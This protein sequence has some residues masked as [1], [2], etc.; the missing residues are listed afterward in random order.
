VT[1]QE[2]EQDTEVAY[3]LGE[4][5]N[6]VSG[7]TGPVNAGSGSQ[8]NVQ[9]AVFAG[10]EFWSRPRRSHRM[11][12]EDVLNELAR[13]FAEPPGFDGLRQRLRV[14]GTVL[15]TGEPGTGRRTTA[16]MVLHGCGDAGRFR[17]LPDHADEAQPVLDPET[18]EPGDRLLLD[19]S[20]GLA[21]RF[22]QLRDQL[23]DHHSVVVRTGAYLVI[24][25]PAGADHQIPGELRHLVCT[26]QRPDGAE[27]LRRHLLADGVSEPFAGE[28]DVPGL[29]V[30]L[31]SDPM[32]ELAKLARLVVETRTAAE[33][34]GS[35][36]DWLGDAVAAM[37]V[38]LQ[39]VAAQ[40]RDNPD[41]RFRALLLASAMFEKVPAEV[42]YHAVD[43]LLRSV[44][45]PADETHRLE[46][47]DLMESL[48][49]I[50]ACTDREQRVRLRTVTYGSATRIHF[51]NSFPGLRA[52][53][54]SWL[55][56]ALRLAMRQ[57]DRVAVL[58]RYSAEC[59]RTEHAE[60]LFWLVDRWAQDL[61]AA[62]PLSAASEVLADGLTDERYGAMF[63]RRIYEW[64]INRRLPRSLALHLVRLCAEAIAP[65]R[66]EQALVRLR[67]LTRNV[68][69][70][71]STAARDTMAMLAA[72]DGHFLRRVLHR[73][74]ED[75]RRPDPWPT[76]IELFA[77][78]TEP[79]RLLIG[80]R[81]PLT[82][83]WFRGLVVEAWRGLMVCPHE[84]WSATA[85]RWLQ[86]TAGSTVPLEVLVLAAGGR[87]DLNA[88]LYVVARDWAA[89]EASRRRTAAELLRRCDLAQGLNLRGE[90][91]KSATEGAV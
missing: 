19:M 82:D 53:L 59:L 5:V 84:R 56:E 39:E 70:L 13:R 16:M 54:R 90:R 4:S 9:N 52:D 65:T 58:R 83:R 34:R 12:A 75:L 47:A 14:P 28:L 67:H 55:N 22:A 63:R 46:R 48:D 33:S 30:H 69:D 79:T 88:K 62:R 89:G 81:A 80:T 68:D 10:L 76:D 36:L 51:W 15:I 72:E 23:I 25:L 77:M 11:I 57:D 74:A 44:G 50:G 35:V 49:R 20:G 32:R 24:V 45:F 8:Y 1:E 86:A 91:S 18:V 71:V 37:S 85:R 66:P 29:A 41:G 38:P 60:D 26:I 27:V 21:E 2:L 64:S 73:L 17:E 3:L 40:V 78:V 31:R 42:V 61:S 43:L 6:A 7:T 87:S